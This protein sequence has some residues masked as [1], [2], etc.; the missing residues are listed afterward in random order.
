MSMGDFG[1]G[2]VTVNKI[3]LLEK[4]RANLKKHRAMF[5]EAQEGYREKVIVA[6]DSMLK[7]ARDGKKIRVYVELEAPED[8]SEDYSCNIEMLEWSTGDTVSISQLQFK[9]FVLDKWGWTEQFA[10]TNAT[11]KKYE[12][13]V[14]P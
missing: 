3:S 11:Y 14:R 10:M 13:N 7:D 4:M 8:R 5:L 12:T 2:S 9:N 1:S 6:L